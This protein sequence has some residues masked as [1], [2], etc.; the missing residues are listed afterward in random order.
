MC[1]L[2]YKVPKK[3]QVVFHKRSNYDYHFLIKELSEEFEGQIKCLGE[4]TEKY[5]TFSVLIKK[6][7]IIVKELHTK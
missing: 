2:R 5:I 6:S 1:N 7:L 3:L 4:N